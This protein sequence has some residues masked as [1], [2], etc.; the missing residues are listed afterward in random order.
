[1]KWTIY[2]TQ[3]L[4]SGGLGTNSSSLFRASCY[5]SERPARCT[6][7]PTSNPRGHSA[8]P[9]E[10]TMSRCVLKYFSVWIWTIRLWI[11]VNPQLC[12]TNKVPFGHLTHPPT[13]LDHFEF[14]PHNEL[15][16]LHEGGNFADWERRWVL[17][18]NEWL[19]VQLFLGIL[20]YV[21]TTSENIDN[22]Q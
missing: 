12:I 11:T 20:I 8:N 6:I 21:I 3:T 5:A 9:P 16:E 19:W 15:L 2:F 10:R 18:L 13:H 1:M 7:S 22:R 17:H 4:R 14:H